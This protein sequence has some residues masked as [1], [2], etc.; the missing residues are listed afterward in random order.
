M[1]LAAVCKGGIFDWSGVYFKEIVH[2]ELFTFGYLLFMI[3]MPVSRFAS[4]HIIEQYG[5]PNVDRKGRFNNDWNCH[6]GYIPLLLALL[7]WL[8]PGGIRN[9]CDDVLKLFVGGTSKKYC[10]GVT[11]ACRLNQKF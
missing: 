3:C 1:F 6:G 5:M 4:D 11:I 8:L 2:E 7:D 10:P 9:I